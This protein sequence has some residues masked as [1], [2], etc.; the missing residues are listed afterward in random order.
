MIIYKVS[1]IT[2]YNSLTSKTLK[3][4]N[5]KYHIKKIHSV[6]CTSTAAITILERTRDATLSLLVKPRSFT[7]KFMC[8]IFTA[9][10]WHQI[11]LSICSIPTSTKPSL[12]KIDS[13]RTMN[14]DNKYQNAAISGAPTSTMAKISLLCN[15]IEIWQFWC[16]FKITFAKRYRRAPTSSLFWKV[17]PQKKTTTRK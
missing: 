11:W 12:A 13:K 8:R 1:C 3:T 2:W 6:P 10:K 7:A 17:K 15:N 5:A 4:R 14:K 9:L 16:L